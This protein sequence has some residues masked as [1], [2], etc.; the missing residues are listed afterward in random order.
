MQGTEAPSASRLDDKNRQNN[1]KD[2]QQLCQY[3]S[4]KKEITPEEVVD[5]L[6]YSDVRS[7]FNAFHFDDPKRPCFVTS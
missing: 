1:S 2:Q 4:I 6:S 7:W 3:Q 5:S